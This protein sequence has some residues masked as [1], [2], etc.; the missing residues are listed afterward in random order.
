MTEDIIFIWIMMLDTGAGDANA[1]T[2]TEQ[3]CHAHTYLRFWRNMMD[4]LVITWIRDGFMIKI[5]L[6]L[7]KKQGLILKGKKYDIANIFNCLIRLI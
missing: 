3:V 5:I 7:G 2:N 6:W 1:E 4:V